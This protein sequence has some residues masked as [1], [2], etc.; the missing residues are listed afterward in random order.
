MSEDKKI[1]K[2]VDVKKLKSEK[3]SK[4]KDII[5]KDGKAKV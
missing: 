3:A 4:L 1:K 5:F 2:K